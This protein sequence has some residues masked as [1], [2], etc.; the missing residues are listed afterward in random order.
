[1]QRQ[2]HLNLILF[3]SYVRVLSTD[4]QL[5]ARWTDL[6]N[7]LHGA[8]YCLNPDIFVYD[9]TTCPYALT[10][11]YTMCDEINCK[12]AVGLAIFFQGKERSNSLKR[13]H[14]DKC[15]KDGSGGMVRNVCQ[16]LA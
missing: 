7:L 3:Q 14:I 12:G 16:A 4:I 6:H 15:S 1:M 10:D 2:I 9:Q 11:L 5:M 8:G 13:Q